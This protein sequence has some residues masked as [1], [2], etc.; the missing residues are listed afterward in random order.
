[1]R[2]LATV[3]GSPFIV[4]HHRPFLI[5][6]SMQNDLDLSATYND[7]VIRQFVIMTVVWGI[8]GM[9]VGAFIAALKIA[10]WRWTF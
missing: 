5:P 3:N 4:Q 9:A 7:K 8:V 10:A 1:M 6:Y 2:N